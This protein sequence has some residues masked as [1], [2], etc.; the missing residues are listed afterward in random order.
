MSLHIEAN[1][2]QP[3][4][5][6]S[7]EPEGI[8]ACPKI[9]SVP[10]A[11]GVYIFGRWF[12]D[13]AVPLYVGRSTDLR[14]RLEQHLNFSLRLMKAIENAEAGTRFFLFCVMEGT[15]QKKLKTLES[16]LIA[17]VHGEGSELLN[18]QGTRADSFQFD[19]YPAWV[20]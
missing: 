3:L 9:G 20:K 2:H 16:A 6:V 10:H 15:S 13:R 1:W 12:G 4:E 7:G 11:C 18:K 19:L 17:H 8:Y 5:L 14:L